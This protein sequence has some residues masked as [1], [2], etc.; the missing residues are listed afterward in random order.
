MTAQ[1]IADAIGGRVI[2]DAGKQ[3]RWLRSVES[4]DESS[5][6]FVE[7]AKWLPDALAS[8][9]SVVIAGEFAVQGAYDKTI[10]VHQ[11]PKLAFAR[12][13]VLLHPAVKIPAG[14]D[15]SSVVDTSAKI[16]EGVFVGPH[17]VIEAGASIG[18][19]T[20]IGSSCVIGAEVRIGKQCVIKSNVTIYPGAVL[21]DRVIVHSGAVLGSDG[22]GYV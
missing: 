17:S 2:G 11:H 1:D 14:I 16:G 6:V 7:D 5:L 19:D 10:I 22:F 20:S 4:A 21:G 13:A 9:A 12:A 15:S 18:N 3:V 8:R